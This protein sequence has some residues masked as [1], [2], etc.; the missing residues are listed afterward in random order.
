MGNQVSELRQR[1]GLTQQELSNLSGVAQPNIAAYESGARIPSAKML[2]RLART[3]KPSP[4]LVLAQHRDE[5][6]ALAVKHKALA[7][8]VFGSVA[9]G[10][11]RPGSDL[12]LLVTFAEGAS[13]YDQAELAQDVEDLLGVEVDVVS[14]GGLRERHAKVRAEAREL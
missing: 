8:K 11:D 10:E 3:A 9:R 2:A 1:A 7:V 12:D 14:A 13:L 6:S 5:V 4:S